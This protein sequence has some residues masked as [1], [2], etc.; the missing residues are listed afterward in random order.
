MKALA[1]ALLLLPWPTLQEPEVL[2]E[3]LDDGRRVEREVVRGAD[4]EPLNDGSYVV[5]WS[6]GTE[7]VRG[8]FKDGLRTGRWETW[9]P[10]GSR[11]SKGSWSSR[12]ET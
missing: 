7:A 11:A 1:L 2:V 3:T 5:R 4:G 6:D 9:H 8:R 10:D 12:S